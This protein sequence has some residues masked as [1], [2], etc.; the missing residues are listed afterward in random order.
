MPP[1]LLDTKGRQ[2]NLSRLGRHDE[3]HTNRAVLPAAF[4]DVA[5]LDEEIDVSLVLDEELVHVAGL[6]D[7]G[8]LSVDRLLEHRVVD[9]DPGIRRR[10]DDEPG[11]QVVNGHRRAKRGHVRTPE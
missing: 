8:R 10:R 3:V 1:R 2:R 6:V 11:S 5:G 7:Q 9:R 4:H